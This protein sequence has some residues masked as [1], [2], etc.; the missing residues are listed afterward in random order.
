MHLGCLNRHLAN[1]HKLVVQKTAPQPFTVADGVGI[2]KGSV[3]KLTS[4][5]TASLADGANDI[6][7]GIS[8]SEK[9][10]GDGL[11]SL[12]VITGPGDEFVAV[13]SGGISLGDPIS[14]QSGGLNQVQSIAGVDL[15]GLKRLGFA[16]ETVT[17]GQ[18]VRYRLD[19]GVGQ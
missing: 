11:T 2:P 6:L 4:P 14:V 15:S 19:L 7:A 12:G 18:N 17:T 16:L 3:M 9:I 5:R 10:A 8:V 1:E 13:A